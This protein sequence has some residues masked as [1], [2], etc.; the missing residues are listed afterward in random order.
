MNQK[1]IVVLK[2]KRIYHGYLITRDA[3][4]MRIKWCDRKVYVDILIPIDM[5]AEETEDDGPELHTEQGIEN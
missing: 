2:D 3:H 5:I 4:W 1:M